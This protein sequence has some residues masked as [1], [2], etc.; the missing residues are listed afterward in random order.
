M[1]YGTPNV[2]KQWGGYLVESSAD[3]VVVIG[4]DS[5][6]ELPVTLAPVVAQP[7]GYPVGVTFGGYI[8][9]QIEGFTKG[10]LYRTCMTVM[11]RMYSNNDSVIVPYYPMSNV[12]SN[13]AVETSPDGVAWQEQACTLVV[14]K[15][16]VNTGSSFLLA[17]SLVFIGLYPHMRYVM[18]TTGNGFRVLTAGSISLF[19]QLTW[20]GNT[21]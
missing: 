15:L 2:L 10:A 11:A 18:T 20:S 17:F 12:V 8:R 1:T 5:F 7:P 13:L 19:S 6:A 16:T 4:K 9:H 14:S 3:S 21:V